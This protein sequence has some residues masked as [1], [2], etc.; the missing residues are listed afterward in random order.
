MDVFP[1]RGRGWNIFWFISSLI[2]LAWN[3]LAFVVLLHANLYHMPY[4]NWMKTILS[5]VFCFLGIWMLTHYQRAIWP[6][7]SKRRQKT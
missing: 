4:E 6:K 3:T 5:C 1:T 2:F 7:K